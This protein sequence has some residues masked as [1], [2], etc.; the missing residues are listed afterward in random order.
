TANISANRASD[1]ATMVHTQ[2]V[3]AADQRVRALYMSGGQ[4]GLLASVLDAQSPSD[5][6][7]RI[8]ALGRVVDADQRTSAAARVSALAAQ[9]VAEAKDAQADASTSTVGSVEDRLRELTDLLDEA[10]ASLDA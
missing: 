7:R 5:L 10:Q 4:T 6:A 2:A 3:R 8:G 1:A 9:T